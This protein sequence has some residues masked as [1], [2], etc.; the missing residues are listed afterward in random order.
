MSS[1]GLNSSTEPTEGILGLNPDPF[2]FAASMSSDAATP[3]HARSRRTGHLTM[4]S[5]WT[6]QA[7]LIA[8]HD[9]DVSMETRTWR[10][11]SLPFPCN[12]HASYVF[13]HRSVHDVSVSLI[14]PDLTSAPWSW[15]AGCG[16]LPR[17][18]AD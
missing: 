5:S 2:R 4:P 13:T 8:V 12:M 9:G 16:S 10:L 11:E 6:Q 1:A 14:G 15:L 7:V 18:R 17:L 3:D